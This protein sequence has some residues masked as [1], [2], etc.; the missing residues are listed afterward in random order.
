[1]TK[2]L[3]TGSYEID[4]VIA[5]PPAR[6]W[7]AITAETSAWWPKE[8]HTSEGAKRF[9]IEP[10]LG[11]R[12]YEDFGEGDGLVWYSVIGVETG[13]ELILAGHLLPPFG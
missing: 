6:V 3:T 11:G 4:I 1:L 12:V 7:Q 8:F 10:V 2:H 5:A 9:V 13:R